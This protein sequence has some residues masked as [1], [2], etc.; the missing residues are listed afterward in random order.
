M[1]RQHVRIWMHDEMVFPSSIQYAHDEGYES[2]DPAS[3]GKPTYATYHYQREDYDTG[4]KLDEYVQTGIKLYKYSH[5]E[6]PIMHSLGPNDVRGVR[7]FTKDLLESP[8][9]TVYLVDYDDVGCYYYVETPDGAREPVS[10]HDITTFAVVGNI[11]ADKKTLFKR[12]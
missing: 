2:D 11:Y 4:E 1:T 3:Y 7:I 8:T 9:G 10:A 6:L 5:N 12:S